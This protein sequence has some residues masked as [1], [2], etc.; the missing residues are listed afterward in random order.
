MSTTRTITREQAA[1]WGLPDDLTTVDEGPE[2]GRAVA[3]YTAQVDTTRWASVNEL[4][5]RAPDDGR[6]YRAL[7]FRGLTETQYDHDVWNGAREVELTEV[8]PVPVNVVEWQPVG[9]KTPPAAPEGDTASAPAPTGDVFTEA[10]IRRNTY[11]DAA[12]EATEAARLFPDNLECAAAIGALEGLA[13]R[14]QR[15]ADHHTTAEQPLGLTWEARADHAVRLYAS[16]AIELEDVKAEAARLRARITELEQQPSEAPQTV[17]VDHVE[18]A[19]R[20]WLAHFEYDLH[21]ALECGEDDGADHYPEEAA[22]FF[23]GLVAAVGQPVDVCA[24]HPGAP[25]IGDMCG[26]CTQYPTDMTEAPEDTV[27]RYARRLNAVERLVGGR[28]GY[29][30]VTVKQL[31]TAMSD[32]DEEPSADDYRHCG[33]TV[34]EGEKGYHCARPDGHKGLHAPLAPDLAPE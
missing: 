27:R 5:F 17:T 11:L 23:A 31:L 13:Q 14:F 4:V 19:L 30:T 15:L 21:K 10:A 34:S 18:T 8:E 22:A 29:D 25:R 3:L 33:A 26:G 24:Q 16:T 28:P 7:Y 20:G 12:R 9:D 32:T 6:T 1:G 2:R